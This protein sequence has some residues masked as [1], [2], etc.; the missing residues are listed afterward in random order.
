MNGGILGAIPPTNFVLPL[1]DDPRSKSQSP[2]PHS[3]LNA[4]SP[5]P[6]PPSNL[7]QS[8]DISPGMI[9]R[10]RRSAHL[11]VPLT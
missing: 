8:T 9:C 7:I 5:P 6:P 1:V 2:H 10:N 11:R 3:L 4:K